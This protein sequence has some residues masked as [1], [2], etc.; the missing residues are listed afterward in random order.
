MAELGRPDTAYTDD[1]KRFANP[2]GA[3][4]QA[5]GGVEYPPLVSDQW[6][7]VLFALLP[8]GVLVC[9]SL[10]WKDGAPFLLTFAGAF[11]SIQLVEPYRKASQWL[12]DFLTEARDQH[13]TA[14]E[15]ATAK[16]AFR[17]QTTWLEGLR[18]VGYSR[19][20]ESLAR[21][22][23]ARVAKRWRRRFWDLTARMRQPRSGEI[24]PSA[25]PRFLYPR[26]SGFDYLHFVRK[27]RSRFTRV[28]RGVGGMVPWGASRLV[29]RLDA[30]KPIV[31][32]KQ[33]KT[34]KVLT[35]VGSELIRAS[36]DGSADAPAKELAEAWGL[37][38]KLPEIKAGWVFSDTTTR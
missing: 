20:A 36:R 8:C 32:W 37:E 15:H 21:R 16:I 9:V 28:L 31:Q 10:V 30:F 3:L 27:G 1:S 11:A 35:A 14:I 24:P 19:A 12:A 23:F 38:Y 26:R 4:A 34:E 18:P 17:N 33:R 29:D 25:I 13:R 6:I 2:M 22:R 7:R 5:L